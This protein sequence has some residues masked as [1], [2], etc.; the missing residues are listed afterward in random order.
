MRDEA[1]KRSG[2]NRQSF[3]DCLLYHLNS[4]KVMLFRALCSNPAYPGIIKTWR[5]M[6]I[7]ALLMLAAFLQVSAKSFSQKINLVEKDMPL[8]KVFRDIKTQTGYTFFYTEEELEHFQP[9]SFSVKGANLETVLNRCFENQVYS[10]TILDKMVV[11]RQ[12][13]DAPAALPQASAALPDPIKVT[14]TVYSDNGLVLPGVNVFIQRSKKGVVTN[15]AGEFSIDAQPGDVVVISYV[16]MEDQKIKV[17]NSLPRLSITLTKGNKLL[18]EVIVE[19]YGS[20]KKATNIV[21]TVTQVSARDMAEKPV[22]DVF[23]ALQGKVPGLTVL[24]SSGEPSSQASL[25]LNGVGSLTSDVTPLIVV[26]GVPVQQATIL[27][28][29]PADFESM[30]VLRDAS[31]TS[32]YGSRA[33]NGVIFFTTK[34]GVAGRDQINVQAQYGA[35]GL[36][37]T[38]FFNNFMNSSELTNFWVATGYHSQGYVDTL[39]QQYPYDTKWYKY[40][41]KNAPPMYQLNV[42]LSGGTGK[43]TYYVSGSYYNSEG[44][45]YHSDFYRYTFRS[46]LTTRVTDWFKLGLNLSGGYNSYQTNPNGSN[47]PD[48]GLS[49]L[50]QPFYSPI[51]PTTH[52]PYPTV[53]PGWGFY[54][55]RYL[56]DEQPNPVN[57]VQL[58][59]QAFIEFTPIKNLVFRSTAG[60]DFY[61][62]INS[63]IQYP[64]FQGSPG[65]GQASEGFS[66]YANEDFNNTLEYT[67]HINEDNHLNALV[68]QEYIDNKYNVFAASSTGQSDDRLVLLTD[69][70]NNIN[71]TSDQYEYAYISYFARAE[72]DWRSKYFVNISGRQDASSLFGVNDRT[73]KFGSVGVMWQAKQENFLKDVSWLSDLSVRANYGSSGNSSINIDGNGNPTNDYQNAA[74]VG[75]TQYNAKSGWYVST[76]GDS[77]LTWEKATQLTFGASIGLWNRIHI[78]ADVYNKVTTSMLLSVPYAYTS[79]FSSVTSNVG[80]LQNRGINLH[81][82]FDV[83]KSKKFNITPYITLNNNWEKVTKLFQGLNYWIVPNT[84][85]CWVIGK[86]VTFFYPVWAGVNPQNGAPQWY[87]PNSDPNK[88]IDPQKDK[89]QVTNNFDPDAL[90]QSTGIKVNPPFK[91]GF[92][93]NANYGGLY[94]GADF[95]FVSGKWIINNDQYFYDNPNVFTG[96]NQSKEVLNYWKKPGDNAEFPSYAYQFTQ[97][98]SHSLENASFIRLKTFTLGYTVP[99]SVLQ[100]TKAIKGLKIYF[101]GRNLLTWTKYPGVDPEVN[102]NL[103]LGTYPNTKQYVGGVDFTF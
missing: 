20:A 60:L 99:K 72:Y 44:L 95:T 27:N 58:N 38:K 63:A 81:I 5:I 83:Y 64:S 8:D 101:T 14:G 23:D 29:N 92:G 3:Q 80:S 66:R 70:P 1:A 16:G 67:F 97:F 25:N 68:G 61:D 75:A 43:T 51:D 78:D 24:S 21:S 42:S 4:I 102:S 49:W 26:D 55:P 56:A 87:L 47:D 39:L 30:N 10:Y 13:A 35:S 65:N 41:Y 50:A 85:V 69:G 59:P 103:E 96:F 76:P 36:T 28:M 93:L 7:T 53:I 22:A 52:Q 15:E 11:V 73:A 84:G 89:S 32:I 33:A 37:D 9:V 18:E 77:N 17:T 71:A 88:I 34:K 74:L 19:G 31:A 98:D 2:I 54:N 100:K 62:R 6:R 91:G 90:Q 40:Y 46:N 12:R 94:L 48:R 79:G 57:T 86:P 45:A 82:D